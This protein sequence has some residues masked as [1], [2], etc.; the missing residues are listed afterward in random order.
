VYVE[1]IPSGVRTITG[2]A[3]SI[4]AFIGRAARGPTDT[5]TTL[6]S[7]A[8]FE[9]DFGG[10]WVESSLGYAIR[11]FFQNGGGQAIAVRLFHGQFANE[12]A[13]A[14]VETAAEQVADAAKGAANPAAAKTAATEEAADIVA[15]DGSAAAKAAA[16]AVAAAV[17]ALPST[18]TMTELG[19]AADAV[20]NQSAPFDSYQFAVGG[21]NL[22]AA[23]PGK[24]GANLRAEIDVEGIADPLVFNLKVTEVGGTGETHLNL[25]TDANSPRHYAKVLAS[26]SLLVR[27]EA[28]SSPNL[29]GVRTAAATQ[30]ST[31]TDANQNALWAA[32][33]DTVSQAQK[34]Y[35]RAKKA[36]EQLPTGDPG[37]AAAKTNEQTAKKEFDA[38]RKTAWDSASD[39]AVLGIGDF[40]PANGEQNKKGLFSLEQA[41]L[42]NLLVIPPYLASTSTVDVDVNL[43]SSAAS[44]CERRR[45]MLLVDAPRDW[46]SV[47]T[48]RTQFTDTADD[49][50]GTRSRNAAL[51]FPRMRRRNILRNNQF[52]EFA[53]A[54]AV[55]GVFAR[56]DVQRGVWK[57]PAGLSAT[58]NDVPQLEVNLTDQENGLLNPLGVNC[59]RAFGPA[60]RVVWGART[61]AGNDQ[62][63]D[64]YKYI[65][66]RRLALFIEESL[67]RGLAWV[68]FEPNDEP[69][70][71]QIRLNVGAF[72]NNL[73][74]QGAFQGTSPRDAYF[75]RCDATTTTQNDINLGIVN[76]V[77]GFAPLKPAEFVILKLQQMAGQIQT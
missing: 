48:A 69:L 34:K 16:Q 36:R 10:L 71:G 20:V 62:L 12:E 35:E 11:D 6:T 74:R 45:A 3:T 25:S 23:Y 54:G 65:P 57:A 1:E 28:S 26:E 44:Y 76:I 64:E 31:P 40:L 17:N 39:G 29:A 13:R 59:L 9:R 24:W 15:G 14:A 4:A 56:T 52:E 55:A 73:F 51:F 27:G 2:V 58:L 8:D 18:A 63:A 46:N 49:H 5:A 33:L 47:T 75:V 30:K 38:A 41:D 42:F 50:V 68:V 77:V 37:L 60:G 72:M 43:I 32:S 19:A 67:F 7:F 21:M 70:W 22:S 53:V 66:V 61:L